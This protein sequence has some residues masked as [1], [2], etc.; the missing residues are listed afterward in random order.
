GLCFPP[1][2]HIFLLFKEHFVFFQ[3]TNFKEWRQVLQEIVR[4][5][6]ADVVVANSRPLRYCLLFDSHPSSHS[7][8]ARFHPKRALRLQQ[9]LLASYH[10][11]E[12]KFTEVTMD[13]FRML[14][15]LEW[16]PSGSFYQMHATESTENCTFSD[17]SGASGLIDINLAA[18]MT[19]PSLPPNPRKSILYRPSISHLIAVLAAISEDISL[20]DVLLIYLSASGKCEQTIGF[21]KDNPGAS[22][23]LMNANAVSQNS[24]KNDKLSS[25]DSFVN[26]N[27]DN[28][29]ATGL[30]FGSRANS[31]LN[32]LYPSDLIPFTRRS[33]FLIIDSDNSR[34]FKADQSLQLVE[35]DCYLSTIVLYGAERGEIPVLLLSPER[36]ISQ[37]PSSTDLTSNGSM[38]TYFLASPLQA[39]CQLVGLS[40]IDPET[41]NSSETIL[42]AA[43]AQWE[44]VLC[45]SD[46][47]SQVYA[48]V[49]PDPFLRRLI[50]RFTGAARAYRTVSG[51]RLVSGT[52]SVF[53]IDWHARTFPPLLGFFEQFRTFPPFLGFFEQSRAFMSFVDFSIYLVSFPDFLGLF[54]LFMTSMDIQSSINPILWLSFHIAHCILSS[55]RFIFCRSVLFL[56]RLTGKGSEYL[57]DCLP[58]LP[59][60]LSPNSSSVQ[61]GILQVA[62]SLGVSKHFHLSNTDEG[63]MHRKEL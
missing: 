9:A 1:F 42:L 54:N 49:L 38:F 11:N 34:A 46:C 5:L 55:A 28:C 24:H 35:S 61:S 15:C 52:T 27:P 58:N 59:D 51:R 6:K 32:C 14:Q 44:V 8:I 33:L 17:Q 31:G 48:Q 37:S 62:E 4:F 21:Q 47:L 63:P 25:H 7:Y 43:F 29:S 19:D 36:S 18:D 56:F 20:E 22:S 23:K 40:D 3:E 57:P 13:T 53:A 50:I 16:E 2:I 12:V 39:F 26:G 30:C 60:S 41:Y 10:R 45:T